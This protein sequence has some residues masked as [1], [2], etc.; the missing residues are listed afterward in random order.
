MT[1]HRGYYCPRYG[2]RY[3]A[4]ACKDRLPCRHPFEDAF[5]VFRWDYRDGYK[6]FVVQNGRHGILFDVRYVT[7]EELKEAIDKYCEW[8]RY[9]VKH[10]NIWLFVGDKG[11]A[12]IFREACESA[13]GA[14][15][16][17]PPR[18]R[19]EELNK[20]LEKNGL[21]RMWI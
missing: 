20:A 9:Q 14:G 4:H 16:D 2:I 17:Y 12:E 15:W 8:L 1:Q 19:I 3:V 5:Y 13:G 7:E 10:D 11:P 6:R 21:P 18:W